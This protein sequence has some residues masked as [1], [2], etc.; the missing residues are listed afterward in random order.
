MADAKEGYGNHDPETGWKTVNSS[1]EEY[2]EG[3]E[4]ASES[5]M[6]DDAVEEST[7]CVAKRRRIM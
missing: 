3:T 6:E 2:E 7:I 1:A 5:V 4:Q